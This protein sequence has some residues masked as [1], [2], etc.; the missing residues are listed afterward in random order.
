VTE[1]PPSL[2]LAGVALSRGGRALVAGLELRLNPG[3]LALVMGP[4]GCGKTTLLRAVAGLSPPS[5]G[6]IRIGGRP[7]RDLEP[8]ERGWIAYQGHLEGLKKD[9]TVEENIRFLSRLDGLSKPYS[10][11]LTALGLARFATRLVRQLSA[12]QKR[13]VA[14]AALKL[15]RAKLWLL[16]EPLT[17]LDAGGRELV[18]GW[19]DEHLAGQGMAMVATHV[20]EELR[21]PGSLL[22][23]L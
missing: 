19:L 16:D 17:N 5:A 6:E 15:S 22:V 13:R 3:Q 2:E 4:N 14:L 7:I 18:T 9:L 10:G 8:E 12:G 1:S 23:E 21:R 20:A 11:I